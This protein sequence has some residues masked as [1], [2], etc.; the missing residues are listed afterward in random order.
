MS[1][2]G[3][4]PDRYILT[5]EWAPF[6]PWICTR[7][8]AAV[9]DFGSRAPI[10]DWTPPPLPTALD[11]RTPRQVHDDWHDEQEV[12]ATH[13]QATRLGLNPDDYDV[14][15]PGAFTASLGRTVPLTDGPGGPVIGTAR[16][17]AGPDGEIHIEGEIT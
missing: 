6:R 4:I 5:P 14:T 9:I 15:A 10:G 12:G 17:T 16:V 3:E 8:G 2:F 11:S 13:R 7:C 1:S